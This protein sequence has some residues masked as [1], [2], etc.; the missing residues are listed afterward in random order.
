M[1]KNKRKRIWPVICLCLLVMSGCGSGKPQADITEANS[2]IEPI[3]FKKLK[4]RM[5]HKEDFMLFVT[6]ANSSDCEV[7]ERTLTAYFRKNPIID[8]Y[9]LSL[10]NQG[11]TLEDTSNAYTKLQDIVPNFSGSVPQIFYFK[12]GK[13]EKTL[14]GK[15]TEISWQNFLIECD[16]ISGKILK[17]KTVSYN[18]TDAGFERVDVLS[19]ADLFLN[20]QEIYLYYARSDRYNEAFSKKLSAYAEANHLRVAILYEEEI[21]L[22]DEKD[23]RQKMEA[24]VEILNRNLNSQFS[25]ALYQIGDGKVQA[26]LK[27]NV[28]KD[29]LIEWISEHPLK[30]Q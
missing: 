23:E 18:I 16:L 15:Q 21:I 22:P 28:S 4:Q 29:V 7:M 1:R 8:I 30:K 10:N 6:Q 26:V 9:E 19:A 14:V 24:A 2:H 11:D 17:E 12:Q 3:Q 13:V 5:K 25:P 20:K 27:D